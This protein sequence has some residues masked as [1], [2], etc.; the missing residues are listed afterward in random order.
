MARSIEFYHTE[1]G[2]CPIRDFL[3]SVDG[4][5]AQK[6]LWVFRLIE[7]IDRVPVKYLKKL[8]G[9]DDIWECR[10]PT[11][12]GTYRIFSFFFRGDRLVVTHGYSKKTQKTDPRE[13]R[14]AERYRLDY[15][16]RHQESSK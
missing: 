3:A 8:A 11:R 15:L 12:S 16:R 6:V 7:R 14:R 13:I 4:K 9:S 2:S 10:V 1:K 5:E